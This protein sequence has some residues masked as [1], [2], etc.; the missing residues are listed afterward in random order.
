MKV[1]TKVVAAEA[2]QITP[3]HGWWDTLQWL[4]ANNIDATVAISTQRP[5]ED[6]FTI[7]TLEGPV[8]AYTDDWIVILDGAALVLCNE[9]FMQFFEDADGLPSN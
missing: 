6:R 3:E 9:R 5:E 7:Y 1:Q 8:T 2:W 4:T